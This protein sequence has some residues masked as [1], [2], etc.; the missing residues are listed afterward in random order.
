M[1]NFRILSFL[2]IIF[3]LIICSSCYE[4]QEGCL[5]INA[6][7]Y[8]FEADLSCEGCC[9]YPEFKIQVN[10]QWNDSTLIRNT[11]FTNNFG[12][13]IKIEEV[14]FY[15]SNFSLSDVN[16]EFTVNETV[17]V[18]DVNGS[19]SLLKDDFIFVENERLNFTVG[20]FSHSGSFS[21]LKFKLGID[22]Y[23]D[24]TEEANSFVEDDSFLQTSTLTHTNMRFTAIVDTMALDTVQF[25]IKG[26]QTVS[27][28][29]L[30]GLIELSPGINFT[31]PIYADYSYLLRNVNFEA[32][33]EEVERKKII[34]N[35]G[36]LFHF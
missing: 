20:T 8:D 27:E 2:T 24:A 5:E 30:E 9:V 13:Q 26:P 4:K 31:I 19:E 18:I 1:L 3:I 7:N 35:L 25:E 6:S 17:E 22:G 23:F 21:K 15:L 28:I 16:T 10:H 32:I 33:Q 11:W 29:T 34:D 12:Q 36:G 14:A